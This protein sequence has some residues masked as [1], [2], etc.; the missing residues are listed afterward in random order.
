MLVL[1]WV[2]GNQT[3]IGC[4]FQ[5]LNQ[6]QIFYSI[7]KIEI[8]TILMYLLELELKVIHKIKNHSTLKKTYYLQ[9]WTLFKF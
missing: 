9:F 8:E 6:N 5:K 4:N 2:S 7:Q 3:K 1:V